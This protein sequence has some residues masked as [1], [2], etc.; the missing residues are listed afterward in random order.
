MGSRKALFF[1]VDGTLLSEETKQAPES[2]VRAVNRARQMGHLAFINS[3]RVSKLLDPVRKLV[4]MDGCLCGCGTYITL[5]DKELY[6]RKVPHETGL[7]VRKALTECGMGGILEGK[8][9]CHFPEKIRM[10]Q[11]QGIRDSIGQ[12][13]C[14]SP[15]PLEDTG[16]DFDKFCCVTDEDS[17]KERFFELVKDEFQIIDRGHDFWEFVPRGHSKATAVQMILDRFNIP[18]EDAYV[19]GDSTN[20]LPMFTYAKNAVLMGKHDRELEPYASFVTKTVEE[21]G[22]EYAMKALGIISDL[23]NT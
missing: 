19:F 1:D 21:D 11:L 3:G 4:D 9:G 12:I 7:M 13:G 10:P 2:A 18:L 22:V 16:Y 17:E 20:D 6:A 23:E 8:G 14:V 5:G 15:L